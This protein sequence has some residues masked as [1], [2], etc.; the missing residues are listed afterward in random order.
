MKHK[1]IKERFI[2]LGSLIK[3]GGELI[4]NCLTEKGNL[5]D[6]VQKILDIEEKG[7]MIQ[8]ELDAHYKN[9]K[10]IPFLAIDQVKLLQ[11]MDKTLDEAS[12]AARSFS[13]KGVFPNPF[14]S[15]LLLIVHLSKTLLVLFYNISLH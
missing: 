12:L 14:S 2:S 3:E 4:A 1:E 13:L 8:D 5:E 10:N 15:C 11:R 6:H 9:E 7:D